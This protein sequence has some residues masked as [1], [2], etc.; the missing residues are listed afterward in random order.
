VLC[1]SMLIGAWFVGPYG[2]CSNYDCQQFYGQAKDGTW[3]VFV[4][5]ST[6]SYGRID[7]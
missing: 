5:V 1:G 4:D 3:S 6:T 7:E 2:K